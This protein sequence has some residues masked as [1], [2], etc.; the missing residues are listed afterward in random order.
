MEEQLT[1]AQGQLQEKHDQLVN[2]KAQVKKM[3]EQLTNAQGQLQEKH[4]QLVNSKAQ[5]KKMEEQLTN[6][7]GQLQEKHDQLVNSKALVK[8]MEEQ[9]TN[10]QGQLQEKHDQLV[11]SK[12]QVK[13]MEEQLTNAQGQLQE[14]HDQLVNSKALVKQMEE[15]LTKAQG[16]LQEKHD[17]LVNSKAQVK[18][19]EEQLTNAQGQLQEKH[20]QLSP[21][22]VISRDQIQ[23]TDKCLGR[24]GWGN[25]VKGKY[26]GCAVAVK[27]IHDLILSNHNRSLFEREMNIASRCRHPCLLQFIGAT[28]DEGSPLFVTELM[29]T[30]LRALLKRP[31]S[32]SELFVISLDVARALNYL[33]QKQPFPIIHRD[34]SSANVLLWRQGDQWRA[35]VSD[36]GTANF[37]RHTMTVAP[38]APIYSAPEA[39]TKNQTVKV[40]VYSFGVLLCEMSIQEMPDPEKR[41]QQVALVSNRVIRALIRGCLQT[42]PEER[43]CM[44][45]IIDELEQPT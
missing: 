12:A 16:Q 17:Q 34:I 20:D 10:A 9:L 23:V 6:A 33:H 19:M 44:E 3:E 2:S 24:G 39:V 42:E 15:Q 29:E 18:Q 36:Y 37:M 7:Q 26:C 25:V 30:S 31:L 14:K 28:N 40:D 13:Q 4:D 5:V 27:Q 1:N 32:A 38:G 41:K 45:E 11:N 21:D 8:Q 43:P 22:W 35:K